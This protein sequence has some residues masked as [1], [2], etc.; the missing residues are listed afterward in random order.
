[1]SQAVVSCV[2]EGPVATVTMHRPAA[3]NALDA[4]MRAGLSATLRDLGRASDVRVVILAGTGRAFCAGADLREP[5]A[6]GVEAHIV[7]EYQPVFDAIVAM[8]QPVISSVAGFAAGAGLSLA[9]VC[10]LTVMADDAYL[11]APFSRIGLVTDCGASWLLARQIGYRR[12][13]EVAIEAQRISAQRALEWGLVNRVEPAGELLVRTA[14]WARSLAARSPAALAATKTA[15]R[16][17]MA[18]GYAETFALE[19]KLQAGCAAGPDYA[20]GVRAFVEKREPVFG[21]PR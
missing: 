1:M 16:F 9:L 13:F 2:R 21:G 8:P 3:A 4:A 11:L 10:D 17:A 12:A 14:D 20:E 7:D 15:M 5:P 6:T 18:H 19:A